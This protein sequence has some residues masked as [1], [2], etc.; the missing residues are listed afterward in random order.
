VD[1]PTDELNEQF[2]EAQRGGYSRDDFGIN[3][4]IHDDHDLRD[5]NQGWAEYLPLPL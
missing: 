2:F 1:N 5:P 3:E 4:D